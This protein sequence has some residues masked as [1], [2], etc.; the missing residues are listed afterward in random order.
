VLLVYVAAYLA[1]TV[2]A[3]THRTNDLRSVIGAGLAVALGMLF[4]AYVAATS[5]A[6]LVLENVRFAA[7]GLHMLAAG[8]LLM[9][10]LT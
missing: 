6:V 1:F 4:I 10:S 8:I 7:L 2:W 5:L 9:L 3:L